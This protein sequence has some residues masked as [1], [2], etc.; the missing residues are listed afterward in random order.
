M[1][2][3]MAKGMIQL[4]ILDTLLAE[5]QNVKSE[6]EEIRQKMSPHQEL[7]DLKEACVR[8]GISY[9]SLSNRKYK[10]LQPNGGVPDII[11]CGR[12]RW[13]WET[14]QKWVTESDEDLAKAASKGK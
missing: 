2:E 3:T 9:G 10:Y 4:P 7:F 1:I 13:R 12:S 11:S 14:I 6:L 8:K 5:L